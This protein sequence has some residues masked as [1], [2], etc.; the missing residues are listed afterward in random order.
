VSRELL[1]TDRIPELDGLR[2][3]ALLLVLIAHTFPCAILDGHAVL[4]PLKILI[5]MGWCGVDLFFV[6]SGF[7]IT[8]ILYN[9]TPS[10]NYF[11]VFYARRILRIFPLYYL[12]LFFF[13]F[14]VPLVSWSELQRVNWFLSG[15]GSTVWYWLF[16]ANIPDIAINRN[17]LL[18]PVWSLSVEEQYY[19]VWPLIV[20]YCRGNL[21]LTGFILLLGNFCLRVILYVVCD[22]SA[23]SVFA[24]TL[25]H[26]DG[27]AL[28]GILRIAYIHGKKCA[29]AMNLFSALLPLLFC[30]FAGVSLF[31][32]FRPHGESV[33]TYHWLMVLLGW[34]LSSLLFGSLLVR[35]LTGA[36]LVARVSSASFLRNVGR[37]SYAMYLLHMPIFVVVHGAVNRFMFPGGASTIAGALIIFA[38]SGAGTYL[39]S[40]LSWLILEGPLND[41]KRAFQYQDRPETP[42]KRECAAISSTTG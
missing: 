39:I 14:L 33:I 32:G 13:L 2:G 18:G 10:C 16:L 37:Y 24:F 3:V 28:G 20:Y 12:I 29:R 19:L 15:H 34:A 9:S 40:R 35:C 41:L 8:G 5:S 4:K 30:L 6:L 36:G 31:C 11:R 38:V 22:Y 42:T 27:L 25:T 7:L 21:L 1:V 17:D 26:L 23:A